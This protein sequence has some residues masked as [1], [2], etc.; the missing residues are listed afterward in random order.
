MSEERKKILLAEDDYFIQDIYQTK[1]KQE[2]FETV[3]AENGKEVLI[4]LEKEIPDLIMLDILMPYMSGIEALRKIKEN[5]EWEKIPVLIL[6]NL[7][8]NEDIDEA[9]SLGANDY[10]IKSQFSPSE[11][12]EK[13]KEIL[14]GKNNNI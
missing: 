2:G 7:S 9:L 1:L 3:L 11:V 14:A 5:E 10:L 12:I 13:V 4:N 6:S 8:Q